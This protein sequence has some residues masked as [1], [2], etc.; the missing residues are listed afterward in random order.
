MFGQVIFRSFLWLISLCAVL[1][2]GFTGCGGDD[3]DDSDWAGTW[4]VESVDA[5]ASSDEPDWDQDI[6]AFFG[7][8]TWTFNR[9]GTWESEEPLSKAMGTYSLSGSSY[10]LTTEREEV[11]GFSIDVEETETGT[12][13]R[14][15]DTLTL[16]SDDGIVR[17][18]KKK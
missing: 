1:I 14:K 4:I 15:G 17:V 6:A 10:T 2:I 8:W 12:W 9:D 11:L 3:D 7:E 5:P 13:S 18:L 16:T